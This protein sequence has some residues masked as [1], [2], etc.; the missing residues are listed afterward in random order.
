MRANRLLCLICSAAMLGLLLAAGSVGAE[1]K[2]TADNNPT[3][4]HGIYAGGTI[5]VANYDIETER[6]DESIEGIAASGFS[7]SVFLG[8]G[9]TH[10]NIYYGVDAHLGFHN[11]DAETEVNNWENAEM[12]IE[13]SYGVSAR[14]GSLLSERVLAYGLAGWQQTNIDVSDDEGSEDKRFD[15]ARLGAGIECQTDQN[16]FIRGEYS[17]ILYGS[18]DITINDVEYDLDPSAGQFQLGIGFRF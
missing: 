2:G 17:Y 6:D 7:N 5:G 11:A 8:T 4:F 3:L 15:G 14:L 9:T 1:A 12:E 18:E 16:V 13:E 10:Q